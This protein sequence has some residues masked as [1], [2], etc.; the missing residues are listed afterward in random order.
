MILLLLST[1][2]HK[3]PLME[4]VGAYELPMYIKLFELIIS[5]KKLA[6]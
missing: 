1:A 6:F 2:K 3:N 5:K 4:K